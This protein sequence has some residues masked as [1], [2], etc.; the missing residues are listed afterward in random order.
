MRRTRKRKARA[1]HFDTRIIVYEQDSTGTAN[2]D[3][4]IPEDAKEVCRRWAE[5]YPLRGRLLDLTTSLEG[6]VT[7][8]VRVHYDDETEAITPANWIV[9]RKTSKRLNIIN[10]LDLDNQHRCIELECTERVT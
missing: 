9:L 1:G 2:T 3:G 10:A 5:V 8:V 6:N 4:E 7:H